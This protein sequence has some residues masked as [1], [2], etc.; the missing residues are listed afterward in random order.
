MELYPYQNKIYDIIKLKDSV[1]LF[2]EA[3][4]G[5]TILSLYKY[6]NSK[7]NV[8]FVVCLA[9]KVDE[10][11]NDCEEFLDN[12]SICTLNKGIKKNIESL[13]GDFEIF[14]VSFQ[15]L[16]RLKDV[17][18]KKIIKETTI[19]IDESHVIK[20][21]KSKI[22]KLLHKMGNK[23]GFKMILT[24]TPQ[25]KGYIDYFSQLKVLGVFKTL[26]SFQDPFCEM[27]IVRYG[28]NISFI[29][30]VGYKNTDLL[31]KIINEVSVFYKRNREDKDIPDQKYINFTK[32]KVYDKFVKD[33]VYDDVGC[34]N[35]AVLR[36]RLRQ[37]CGGSIEKHILPSKKEDWIKD[38][39]ENT[40]T[41]IVIFY[42]FNNECDIISNIVKELKRPLSIYNGTTKDIVNFE[43]KDDAVILVNYKSGGTGINWLKTAYMCVFY[44]PPESYLEFE[45]AR[46]RLDRIGQK[47]KPMFYCLQTKG[48][49][50][51]AIYKTI[52]KKEEFDNSKFVEYLKR[53]K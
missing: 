37:L 21:H 20:N 11:V 12:P 53:I 49:V 24:G 10:W 42:N 51:E 48:T 17:I 45:Q 19:L 41:K 30:V 18:I 32:H 33:R 39:I 8:L 35:L 50:E 14:I 9:S 29:D 7:S 34:V 44:S 22:S 38:F 27:G 40:P 6:D 13:D 3:G 25:N 23:T 1:A 4:T 16:L 28:A 36:L 31:D 5:K 52:E 47:N 26:I 46:K 15:S 2:L 43:E